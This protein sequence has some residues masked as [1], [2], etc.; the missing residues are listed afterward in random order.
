MIVEAGCVLADAQAAAER[1]AGC[2]RCRP[3]SE[4]SCQIGG[5]LATN[6]GGVARAALR[7]RARAVPRARG[8]AADGRVWDGLRALKKDNTGYDLRDLFI[9][10]EGTLGIITAA[11]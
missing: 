3:P 6:A 5:I 7:Q 1:P 9:G 8:G 4:G 2:F 10:S 11:A